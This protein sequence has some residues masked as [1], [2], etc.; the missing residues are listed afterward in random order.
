VLVNLSPWIEIRIQLA[1]LSQGSQAQLQ[2]A[3]FRQKTAKE[4]KTAGFFPGD[5]NN[6]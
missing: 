3:F 6:K 4:A 5:P 2:P 1:H